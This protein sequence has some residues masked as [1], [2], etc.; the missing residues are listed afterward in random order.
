[1][2]WP[3]ARAAARVWVAR[4]EVVAAGFALLA[5]WLTLGPLVTLDGWPTGFPSAYRLLYEHVP[6]FSSGRA[7][8]RF[9]MVAACFAALAAA[10]GLRSVRRTRM[11][12]RIAWALCALFLAE[13]A[14]V[15]LPLSR[16]WAMPNVADVPHWNG[17]QPSAI[18]AAVRELPPD[19]V[20][21]FLPFRE[22]FH[23]ARAMFDSTFH[24]RRMVNGYSSWMP[25]EYED[26]AFAA[27]DPLRAP[28]ETLAA[29]RAAGVTHVVVN[30]RAWR[31]VKGSRVAERLAAAGARPIAD[32]GDATLLAVR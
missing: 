9:A 14:P 25:Q 21:A 20:L 4:P 2:A 3:R 18:V 17:G 6:G 23:E 15:P 24:W 28:A 26:L 19:A 11:G 10:Y 1:V 5:A 7:A 29:L 13:T 22:H 31:G 8:A 32:A 30:E 27:R 12:R 16:T